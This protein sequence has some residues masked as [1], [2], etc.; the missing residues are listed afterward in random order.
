MNYH[1][2]RQ[3]FQ[4]RYKK[5]NKTIY[6]A[7]KIGVEEDDYGHEVA[8]YSKP[9]AYRMNVQPASS[10]ADV[11]LFGEHAHEMQKIVIE[12]RKYLN[13]FKEFDV[14]YLDGATPADDDGYKMSVED[15][16]NLIVEKVDGVLVRKLT[17]DLPDKYYC[18][19]ANYRLY[20]P[21]NQNKCITIYFERIT[22]K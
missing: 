10:K 17:G 13:Q 20:P 1:L 11:E 22:G 4:N 9:K 18:E 3:V 16:A 8:F 2:Q 15:I 12:Q 7:N 14:A 5:W 21:R 19:S 6:I